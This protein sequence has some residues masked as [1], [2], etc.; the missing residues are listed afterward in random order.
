MNKRRYSLFLALFIIA[1][2]CAFTLNSVNSTVKTNSLH[3]IHTAKELLLQKINWKLVEKA[4]GNSSEMRPGNVFYFSLPRSDLRVTVKGIPIRTALALGGWTAFKQ[5]DNQAMVMGDLVLKE[6][7]VQPVMSQLF[8]QGMEVSA[9]HNHLLGESPRIMYLHIEGH[10]DPIL[11]AKAIRSGLE[12]TTTPWNKHTEVD[13]QAFPIDKK[14]L[15]QIFRH[16]GTVSGGVY[17][18]GIPRL[19]KILE[20]GMEILPAMGV[21]TLIKFQP[22]ENGKKAAVT[23]DFVLTVDEVNPV[24]RAL[25]KHG[26]KVTALHNHMLYEQPRLFFMHFWAND[27]P[28]KLAKGLRQAL[29][30]TRSM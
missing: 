14:K 4:M 26:I 30:K 19:E 21:A 12:L 24:A 25:C 17:H 27:D 28:Y 11:L 5:I 8:S 1:F 15:D 3:P 22:T 23:G 9:L 16:I 6:E 13:S 20:N 2:G 29:D 7:E 10:G 18:V